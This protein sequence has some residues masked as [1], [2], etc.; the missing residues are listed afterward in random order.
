MCAFAQSLH[1]ASSRSSFRGIIDFCWRRRRWRFRNGILWMCII[2]YNN[3]KRWFLRYHRRFASDIS[4]EII[5]ISSSPVVWFGYTVLRY[6]VL[7]YVVLRYVAGEIEQ[8][9]VH[10]PPRFRHDVRRPA[11][12]KWF[13][14]YLEL[15][16]YQ[17]LIC[18]MITPD[19]NSSVSR[20]CSQRFKF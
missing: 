16:F 11:T 4:S 1:L 18:G 8:K 3:V 15:F 12:T 5:E 2:L 6:A 17:T 7:R 20:Q 10:R 19:G 9:R 13:V 14:D